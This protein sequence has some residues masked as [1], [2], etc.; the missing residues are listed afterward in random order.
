MNL[1]SVSEY[2]FDTQLRLGWFGTRQ[3]SSLGVREGRTGELHTNE[4][5]DEILEP[6]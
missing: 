6:S 3:L 4:Y 5:V 2:L 1:V